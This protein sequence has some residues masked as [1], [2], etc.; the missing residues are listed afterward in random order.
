MRARVADAVDSLDRIDPRQQLREGDPQL[1]RQ[2]TPVAVYVLAQQGQLAHAI[3]GQ[4]LGLG[5]QL[6]RIAA[7]LS[8]AGRGNDAVSALAIA[9]LRDL[10]PTLKLA[11]A[12]RRQVAGKVLE[13]EVTLGGKRV[14]VEE[15]GQLVDLAGTECDVNEGEALENLL[16]DRLRPAA[17]DPNHAR[18]VFGLEPLR[19]TQVG[20]EAVVRGL[21]DRAG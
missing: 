13:L 18:G 1:S 14:R 9:A 6:G 3:G 10:Q 12:P 7:L 21:A 16:L 15:L 8:A 11:L 2:V 20:D 17:P 5:D 4:T 19:L